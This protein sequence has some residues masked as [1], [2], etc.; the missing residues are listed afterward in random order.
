[1]I[2]KSD[3]VL[4]ILNYEKIFKINCEQNFNFH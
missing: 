3:M 4:T 1:M 2:E